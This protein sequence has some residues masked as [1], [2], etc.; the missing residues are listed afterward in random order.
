MNLEQ[1]QFD[2][3]KYRLSNRD[4]TIDRLPYVLITIHVYG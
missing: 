4:S 1:T 2:I 3:T